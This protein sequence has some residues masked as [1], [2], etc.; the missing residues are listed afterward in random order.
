MIAA[1]QRLTVRQRRDRRRARTA[2][3]AAATTPRVFSSCRYA[4]N[5]ILPSATTTRTRGSAAI[6]ASRCGRQRAI[7]SGVGLLSGGAQRT[8]AAMNASVSVSPSS[9]SLRRRDVGE[10]GAV[11]RGHQEVAR[12]ADAVAG[13][14]AAGAVGAVRGRRQADDQQPRARIAE[15]RHRPR[16]VD[17]VAKRATL[18]ATDPLA[19]LTQPRAA[20][21]GDDL[22]AHNCSIGI[23]S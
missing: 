9:G 3:A 2:G 16:P 14:D 18:F 7:S 21:A 12:A 22:F 5:A 15:A 20:F 10:A 11:Q 23:E 4:S 17:V 19:V 1:D 8:A 13:E 6:S